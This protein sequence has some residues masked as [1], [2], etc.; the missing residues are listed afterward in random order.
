MSLIARG[1]L[2]AARGQVPDNVVNPE[3]LD[4]P[5]FREKLARF[6]ANRLP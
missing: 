5:G 1:M 2:A 4:R 6:R 3:V